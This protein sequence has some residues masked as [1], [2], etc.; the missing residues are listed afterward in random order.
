[1]L[2]KA[3]DWG[4]VAVVQALDG[5]KFVFIIILS[6]LVGRFIPTTAGENEF[7]Y[8][9]ITRKIVYVAIISVGFLILFT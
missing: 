9:T 8:Q 3:T 7:D 5:L 6:V 4:D 2:L 1:M